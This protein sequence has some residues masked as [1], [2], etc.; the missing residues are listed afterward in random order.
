MNDYTYKTAG[1]DKYLHRP[2]AKSSEML[3]D[4]SALK[5]NKN[6]SQVS[7][8]GTT[9]GVGGIIKIDWA[10]GE[11]V[12]SS[13]ARPRLVIGKVEETGQYGIKLYDATGAVHWSDLV[14]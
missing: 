10:K 6:A 11:L 5:V 8:Y 3:E 14:S 2:Q 1:Y 13:G 7:A 9:E 12:I 4:E